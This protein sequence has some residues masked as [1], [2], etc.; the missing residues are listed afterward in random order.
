MI[1]FGISKFIDF[2][3]KRQ[4]DIKA[5]H[6][7]TLLIDTNQLAPSRVGRLSVDLAVVIS[8]NQGIFWTRLNLS[9][10]SSSPH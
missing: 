2:P 4:H 5:T 3:G 8:E 10:Q 1:T 7:R 9:Y 6:L